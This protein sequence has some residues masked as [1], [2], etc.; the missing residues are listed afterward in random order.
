MKKQNC[1]NVRAI[2]LASVSAAAMIAAGAVWAAPPVTTYTLDVTGVTA[3][4]ATQTNYLIDVNALPDPQTAPTTATIDGSSVTNVFGNSAGFPAQASNNLFTATAIGNKSTSVAPSD[5]I[6][7]LSLIGSDGTNDGIGVLHALVVG[8][9]ATGIP[10][11][12]T[13]TIAGGAF[14]NSNTNTGDFTSGS[15]DTS[16]NTMATTVNVNQISPDYQVRG[17]VPTGYSSPVQG[18]S[19]TGFVDGTLSASNSASVVVTSVQTS[20]MSSA[21][22]ES[23]SSIT[24]ASI[25]NTFTPSGVTITVSAPQTV[26]N[27][28]VQ[29]NFAV[30]SAHNIFL[31]EVG[32]NPTFAGSVLVSNNQANIENGGNLFNPNVASVSGVSVGIDDQTNVALYTVIAGAAD[33]SNNAV[34][35]SA[36]GNTAGTAGVNGGAPTIGNAIAFGNGLNVA[37]SGS[38]AGNLLSVPHSVSGQDVQ[39]TLGGDLILGNGQGNTQ[40]DVGSSTDSVAVSVTGGDLTAAGTVNLNGNALS[41]AATGN[42]AVGTIQALGGS[43]VN[44][45]VTFAS[46]QANDQTSIHSSVTGATVSTALTGGV[47]DTVNGTI[48]LNG[49]AI[50]ATATGNTS[51]DPTVRSISLNATNLT[52]T[53]ALAQ[54]DNVSQWKAGSPVQ[55]NTGGGISA[56]NVQ[57]NFGANLPIAAQVSGSSVTASLDDDA[58]NVKLALS[59]NS[60]SAA[61]SGNVGYTSVALSGSNGAFSAGVSNAQYGENPISASVSGGT[62]NGFVNG[63]VAGSSLVVSNNAFG[64][65]AAANS[66]TNSLSATGFANLT[67]GG[68]GDTGLLMNTHYDVGGLQPVFTNEVI[69]ALAVDNNQTN[70]GN[71]AA[72]ISAPGSFGLASVVVNGNITPGTA[73]NSTAVTGNSASSSAIGSQATNSLTLGGGNLT[74]ASGNIDQIATLGSVQYQGGTNSTGVT[75]SAGIDATGAPGAMGVIVNGNVNAGTSGQGITV[76]SNSLSTFAAGNFGTNTLTATGTNYGAASNA[77]ALQGVMQNG[78]RVQ[79]EFALQN[80]QFDNSPANNNS[81]GSRTA[82]ITGGNIGISL[83][84]AGTVGSTP[85]TVSGNSLDADAR[86]NYAS[87]ALGLTGF[88]TLSTSAGLI[89]F[90][91]SVSTVGSSVVN[92]KV[93]LDADGYDVF[94][95]AVTVSDNSST[96]RAIA[97]TAFNSVGVGS[98]SLGGNAGTTGAS[99]SLLQVPDSTLFNVYT[100]TADYALGSYQGT[101]NNVTASV[102]GVY[103]LDL[104]GGAIGEGSATLSGNSMLAFAQNNN[105]VNTLGIAA[106]TTT[107]V[108]GVLMSEQRSIAPTTTATAGYGSDLAFGGVQAGSAI[109]T[110]ISVS[111][112]SLS[113][114]AGNNDATNTLTATATSNLSGAGV[115]G[116][117]VVA[118]ADPSNAGNPNVAVTAD[119]SLFN[120]QDAVQGAITAT[121]NPGGWGVNVDGTTG[122]SATTIENNTVTAQARVNDAINTLSLSGKNVGAS[123]ALGNW[124]ESYNPSTAT[125]SSGAMGFSGGGA[126]SNSPLNVSGN[127][128]IAS[129][130]GNTASNGVSVTA[131]NYTTPINAASGGTVVGGGYQA[132][133]TYAVLNMQQ[134]NGAVNSSVTGLNIGIN[135]GASTPP[136]VSNSPM[137]VSGNSVVASAYG[138]SASNSITMSAGV[139]TLPSASLTSSQLNTGAVTSTVTGVQI[140]INVGANTGS[141]GVSSNNTIGAVAVGNSVANTVGIH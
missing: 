140:G 32:D 103:Q 94:G 71:V 10:A 66:A 81:A 63:D 112:N 77:T 133:A 86:N 7:D 74:T 14:T 21:F 18:T 70:D 58:A 31:A 48:T 106:T 69:G 34:G 46:L 79:A 19:T 98:T 75:I 107:S 89:N 115:G 42:S 3:T 54:I 23:V 83:T 114:V 28:T 117:A 96:A 126:I 92:G 84:A 85:L 22:G 76:D 138:N 120:V 64:A 128:F 116:K 90:Q 119:F 87:N 130:G 129:A 55:S 101:T 17:T 78:T 104:A 25:G 8:D 93:G 113:A 50:G 135:V 39:S 43:S 9:T 67:V 99:A 49:N 4:V 123:A 16:N 47:D 95:S 134:N 108:S 88:S 110:P 109:D 11:P 100:A 13:A 91:N 72:A 51:G 6:V 132:T 105:V 73:L 60:L 52:S 35:S 53:T 20:F 24:G 56:A 12:V 121:A 122:T 27:N 36:A 139:G 102:S 26:D 5:R 41:S 118:N 136:S 97:N 15:V 1:M 82:T 30:N 124:Q 57:A 40:T 2:A 137:S 37:G 65:S 33:V 44:G 29:A 62:V 131:T 59:G 61:A 80:A 45:T 38:T 125:V 68:A 141:S 127:S 111:G